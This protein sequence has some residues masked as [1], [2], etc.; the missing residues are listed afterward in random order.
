MASLLLVLVDLSLRTFAHIFRHAQ[1]LDVHDHQPIPA[2]HLLQLWIVPVPLLP[3]LQ[4]CRGD[5]G[6]LHPADLHSGTLAQVFCVEVLRQMMPA[7]EL[8]RICC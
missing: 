1:H 4:C 2:E 6:D 8:A 5:E 7:W 3:L